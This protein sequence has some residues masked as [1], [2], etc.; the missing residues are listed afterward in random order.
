MAHI[1]SA[2]K[3]IRIIGERRR[4]NRSINSAVKT[5]I[6]KAEELILDKELEPAREAV[7]QATIALDRAAQKGII[8]SNN[9]ARRKSRLMKRFNAAFSSES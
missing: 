3:S 2:K 1:K 7:K 6:I 4:R 9:A 5:S 8:H